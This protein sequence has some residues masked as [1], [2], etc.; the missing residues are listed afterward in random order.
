M[1]KKLS[2]VLC[3]LSRM[4][5]V[6]VFNGHENEMLSSRAYREVWKLEAVLNTIYFWEDNHCRNSFLWEEE[7]AKR[8]H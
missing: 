1:N 8:T 4:C 3:L 6:I 7:R 5:N 2:Q